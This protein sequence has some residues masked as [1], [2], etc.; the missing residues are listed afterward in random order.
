V[1][2]YT[3]NSQS[4]PSVAINDWGEFVVVWATGGQDGDATGIAGQQFN[5]GG[6]LFG[7]EFLVNTTTSGAQTFPVVDINESGE[8]MVAWGSNHGGFGYEGMGQSFD[9]AGTPMGAEMKISSARGA[10]PSVAM[11]EFGGFIAVYERPDGSS[12]GVSGQR[13]TPGGGRYDFEFRVNTYSYDPQSHAEVGM[14]FQG[15]FVVVWNSRSQDGDSYGIFGRAF[16]GSVGPRGPES[17]INEFTTGTQWRPAIGMSRTG[18]FVVAWASQ[19]QDGDDYGVFGRRFLN[20]PTITVLQDND[21][22][23]C[24]DPRTLRPAITWEDYDY[25]RFK[26]F[27]G[28]DPGFAR[29]TRVTSGDRWIKGKIWAPSRKKWRRVCRKALDADPNNPV[30]YIQVRGRDRDLGKRH[31]ARVR[32]SPLIQVNIQP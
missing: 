29:G 17:Q 28:S 2:T 3:T 20:R 32:A 31:P 5:P 8:F 25:D 30:L 11:D 12:A 1:N 19:D 13:F 22:L 10:E 23:D 6:S 27:M 14:T 16:N 24:S 26:V 21:T 18:D 4:W 9:A 7:S 15:S